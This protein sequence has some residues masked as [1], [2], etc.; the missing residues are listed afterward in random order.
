MKISGFTCTLD[1]EKWS[2]P[3]QEALRSY[4]DVFDEVIVIDGGSTDGS[5]EK[6]K[7]I[8]NSIKIIYLEWPW[9]YKQREFA[10]HYNA[11]FKACTGDWT[12]KLDCDWLF[13]ETDIKEFRDK[14]KMHVNNPNIMAV[15]HQKL[16]MLN[17]EKFHEKG[18]MINGIHSKFY[19]DKIKCGVVIGDEKKCDWTNLIRVKK[20]IDGVYYGDLI[21]IKNTFNTGVSFYNYDC[22][23]RTKEKCK[24]W[25]QRAAKAFLDETGHPLYGDSKTYWDM[26]KGMMIMRKE[27]MHP[28]TLKIKSHPKYIQEKLYN[29]TPDMWGFNNWDWDI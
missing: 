16:S 10:K 9:E 12:F 1:P 24:I 22:F 13:H 4:L 2:F 25:Y 26:W 20:Q 3:Y 6:I 18:R 29:M 14:L 11:G 23:F 17:R 19:K 28:S 15:S 21:P 5:L 8:S 7:A 27:K